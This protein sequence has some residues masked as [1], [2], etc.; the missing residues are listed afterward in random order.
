VY[1]ELKILALFTLISTLAFAIKYIFFT[2]K[3]KRFFNAIVFISCCFLLFFLSFGFQVLLSNPVYL[4]RTLAGFSIPLVASFYMYLNSIGKWFP[5]S[6]TIMILPLAC[7]FLV[8]YKYASLRQIESRL[9]YHVA[10][11]IVSDLNKLKLK[12]GDSIYAS[13]AITNNDIMQRCVDRNRI[14]KILAIGALSE[15]YLNGYLHYHFN[16]PYEIEAFPK[17]EI[18]KELCDNTAEII[19]YSRHYIIAQ[20]N[21]KTI[22]ALNND[23]AQCFNL[24]E[25]KINLN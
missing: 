14:L 20:K 24:L 23:Y 12:R 3:N 1:L 4:P 15:W 13:G 7:F 10:S 18:K 11:S 21:K 5:R 9:N 6:K 19:N 2:N 8:S 17:E 25:Q 22:I 16:V